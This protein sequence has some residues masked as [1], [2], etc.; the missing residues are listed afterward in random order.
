MILAT[1]KIGNAYQ[2]RLSILLAIR[3]E[4]LDSMLKLV[5]VDYKTKILKFYDTLIAWASTPMGKTRYLPG[6]G[7]VGADYFEW[8][9]LVI[10]KWVFRD[11]YFEDMRIRISFLYGHISFL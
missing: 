7:M 11:G 6:P 4:R 9:Y 10:Q 1:W 5:N 3:L 8:Q 2:Y